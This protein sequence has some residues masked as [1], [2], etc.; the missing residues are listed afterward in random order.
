M[1]LCMR[2]VNL[3]KRPF[4]ELSQQIL[5]KLLFTVGNVNFQVFIKAVNFYAAD[6]TS[7]TL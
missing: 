6:G 1:Q 3:R 7:F 2:L 4:Q 5:T